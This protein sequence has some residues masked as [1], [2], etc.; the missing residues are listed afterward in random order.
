MSATVWLFEHSLPLPFF[1]IGMK[2]NLFQSCGHWW[3]FQICWHIE[4]S[5]LTPSSFRIWN[6]SAGILPSPPLALFIVIL[7]KT[8]L[9]SHPR[10]SGSRF[11]TIALQLSRSLWPLLYRSFVYSCHIFLTS[12]ASVRSL[13]FLSFIMPISTWN[14]PLVSPWIPWRTVVSREQFH[15]NDRIEQFR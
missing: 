5:N 7:P 9:T 6:S 3:V 14:V 11:V 2:T 4:C 15:S 10:M 13:P 1:G 12:S 8:H